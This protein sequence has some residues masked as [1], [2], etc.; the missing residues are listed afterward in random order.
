[1]YE[2]EACFKFIIYLLESVEFL[3]VG[4]FCRMSC[5]AMELVYFYLNACSGVFFFLS[6]IYLFTFF[7]Y[8]M[9]AFSKFIIIFF[10]FGEEVALF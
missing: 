8:E 5:H 7:W 10:F 6:L 4:Q 2:R 1:M 3:K 9:D